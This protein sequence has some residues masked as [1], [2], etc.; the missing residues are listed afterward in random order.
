VS[1][2]AS[3][4]LG[5]WRRPVTAEGTPAR[6]VPHRVFESNR[7]SNMILT[8]RLNPEILGKRVALYEH[9][10]F[11]EGTIG[12]FDSFDQWGVELGKQ[13]AQRIIPKAESKEKPALAHD[14]LTNNLINQHRKSK[15]A[16]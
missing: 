14:N 9:S 7:A 6:L 15:E 12:N 10:V 3:A 11:T 2:G 4:R 16:L 5:R 13:L 8:E 1:V